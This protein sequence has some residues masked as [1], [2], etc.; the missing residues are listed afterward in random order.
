MD[1][2]LFFFINKALQNGFFDLIM[3]FISNR[4]YLP[5]L[6]IVGYEFS[7]ERKRTLFVLSLCVLAFALGDSSAN[8]LKHLFERPRPC[9]ALEGVR[10]LTACGSSF[11]FPSGHAVNSFAIAAVFS[12][13]FRRTAFLTFTLAILV[14]FSRIYIGAH[15][16]SDVLAGAIWGGVTAWVIIDLQQWFAKGYKEKPALTIFIASLIALTFFRYYYIVTGPLDLSP[17]E[18]HYWEWARRLDMSYYSKGPMIAWLIGATTWMMG[19]SLL[20]V[21]FFAPLFLGFSSIF[22]YLLTMDLFHNDEKKEIKACVTALLI[23]LT[24]LFSAYGILMTIDSPFIFFWTLSLYLFWKAVSG[25]GIGNNPPTPPLEK[26]G[27]GGFE[28]SSGWVW[29]LLGISIGL[30]LL[31]K[32][33]MA[34]FYI[35]GFFFLIF[36][37]EERRWFSRKEPYIA[38][39]VSLLVFSPVIIWNA[40][41]DWVTL[42]HTAGQAHISEGF[43]ISL[44]Y[45]FDFIGSQLGVISP[46]VFLMMMYG[47]VKNRWSFKAVQNLRFLFW[48]WFPVLAFFLIKSLQGKVQANWAMHAYITAFIASA[49]YFL[50]KDMRDKGLKIL[51]ASSLLILLIFAVVTYYPSLIK[52]PVKQ[53]PASRLQGWKELG[54][55]TDEIYDDM[56]SSAERGVF[57]FSDKYQVSGELAFYMKSHPV[58]YNANLGRRMNQYDMWEGFESLTGYDAVF[59]RDGDENFPHELKDAFGHFEKEIFTVYRK[60]KNVLRKYVIFKCYNFRGLQKNDFES[61]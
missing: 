50:N 19:D 26:G 39:I 23:Q 37:K 34:F 45:F 53:D 47:A 10:L 6:L 12:H 30:G 24:P 8:I 14:A 36:S 1:T 21:R 5:F 44:K 42:K 31:T 48:F 4:S 38:L 29:I 56:R 2:S 28:E 32:Y 9:H 3:P 58:T 17:D 54:V 27:K 11:S 18:A 60:D 16:P 41:H 20:G 40:G 52:L 25:Q 43:K 46:L 15:Y 57:I 35:C 13:F 49:D 59:V 22:V 55:K 51:M 61:Y 7:K 33:T